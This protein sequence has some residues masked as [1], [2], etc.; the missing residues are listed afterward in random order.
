MEL[1]SPV[2]G[3]RERSK[4]DKRRRISE[5]ARAVF[6][7]FGYERANMREIA[8]RAGVAT[9][10]LFLY[11]PDKRNLLLWILND[12]L[13]A[14]TK[15]S[16]EDLARDHHDAALLDQLVFVFEARYRY[17]GT[18]PELSLHALQELIVARDVEPGHLNHFASYQQRRLVLKA[19]LAEVI[20]EQQRRGRI[21]PATDGDLLARLVLAIYNAAVR[22]W[23]REAAPDLALGVAE[24]RLLLAL[25]IAGCTPKMNARDAAGRS[26]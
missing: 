22:A 19:R 8:K 2:V 4:L 23:L 9:G 7:E 10:T 15:A 12:D 5:A 3:R 16:F 11:A 20:A 17:W 14:V 13:E 6:T 25:A 21:D 1:V 18:D 24:L 26:N